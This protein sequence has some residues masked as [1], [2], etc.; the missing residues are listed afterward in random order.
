[1]QQ[2]QGLNYS[3]EERVVR[4]GAAQRHR[5]ALAALPPNWKLYRRQKD[6]KPY[7]HNAETGQTVWQHP[8]G[9][10]PSHSSTTSAMSVGLKGSFAKLSV[11]GGG[12]KSELASQDPAP[13]N[14]HMPKP[15]AY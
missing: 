8:G 1:M 12:S 11:S 4:E 5:E 2:Q 13:R 15:L 14:I 7:Y 6:C 9:W 3:E 10:G